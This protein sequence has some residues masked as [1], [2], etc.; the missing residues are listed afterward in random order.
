MVSFRSLGKEWTNQ[1]VRA[2]DVRHPSIT[3]P[4]TESRFLSLEIPSLLLL[5][6]STVTDSL[7]RRLFTE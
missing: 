4:E 2:M 5:L 1:S 3:S 6:G 7:F